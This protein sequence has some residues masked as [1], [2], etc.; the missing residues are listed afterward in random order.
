MF[1]SSRPRNEPLAFRVGGGRMI[2]GF[3]KM[4]TGLGVGQARKERLEPKDAYGAKVMQIC[5]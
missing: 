2:A 3:D 4:V 1:D 5:M